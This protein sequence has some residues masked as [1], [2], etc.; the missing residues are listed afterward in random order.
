[1]SMRLIILWSPGALVIT[2]GMVYA[3][4][5]SLI[6]VPMSLWRRLDLPPLIRL[7]FDRPRWNLRKVNWTQEFTYLLCGSQ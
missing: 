6:T 4:L 3:L 7:L 1:M 2:A 5:I